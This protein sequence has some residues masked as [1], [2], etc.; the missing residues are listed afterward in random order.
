ML[1]R[2]RTPPDTLRGVPTAV[3]SAPHRRPSPWT[4]LVAGSAVVVLGCALVLG[5]WWLRSSEKRIATYS[6][7]GAVSQITLDL[8]GA[9]TTVVGGGSGRAVRVQRT[10]HFSFGRR[11]RADRA[12]TGG[13]LRLRSRCP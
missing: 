6:V 10:D 5:V 9:N 2:V 13:V 4:M 1:A 7:R 8:G 3:Q 12:V 11:A